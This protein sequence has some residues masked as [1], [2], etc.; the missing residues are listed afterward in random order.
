MENAYSVYVLDTETTGFDPIENDVIE[1]SIL[2]MSDGEQKTWFMKPLSPTTI[3]EDA[4]RVNK[5]ILADLLHKTVEGKAKYKEPS[6]ILVEIENW[7][8]EDGVPTSNRVVADTMQIQF[9]MDLC[10]QKMDS[11]YALSN[12]VKRYS[13]KN[14]KA[15]SAEADTKVTNQV[16]LKQM[17]FL[18]KNEKI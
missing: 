7:L 16:L 11:G 3:S 14:E 6:E 5:H 9:F 17:D 4:L 13:L 8:L 18:K 1:L 2:R 10:H 12:L 15:H